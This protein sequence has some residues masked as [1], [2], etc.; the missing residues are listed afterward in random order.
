MENA[1]IGG[2]SWVILE[3]AKKVDFTPRKVTFPSKSEAEEWKEKS[4]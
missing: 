4:F 3:T 1:L 2:P